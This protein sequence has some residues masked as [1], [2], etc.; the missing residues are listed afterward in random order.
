MNRFCLDGRVINDHFPGIGRYPFNLTD[1]LAALAPEDLFIVLHHPDQPNSRYD[2]ERLARHDNVMLQPVDVTAFS[3]AQQ[4]RLPQRLRSLAPDVYHAP[5]YIY[6][7]H[8]PYPTVVTLFDVI[9]HTHPQYLP[10]RH[11]RLIFEVT[12]R[13]ALRSAQRVLVPSRGTAEVVQRSYRVPSD[14][15]VVTP[16][17]ADAQF[18]LANTEAVGK[19]R[20]RY[21]LPQRYVLYLGSNK[22]HKNLLWLV[23]AWARVLRRRR[24]KEEA[25]LVI[26]GHTDP[27]YPQAQAHATALGVD[28]SV[29]FLGSVPEEDLPPLYSGA[30]CF[31]FP[32]LAEGFGLPVL[33]AMACGT[34]VLCGNLSSLPEVAGEAALLVNPY[35]VEAITGGLVRL[36]TDGDLRAELRQKGLARAAQFTWERTARATLAAYREVSG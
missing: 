19:V 5:Y 10:S 30:L 23:E 7:Y 13:L 18:R 29:R 21:D 34:P 25:I 27:R 32:S 12:T 36:L 15:V 16:L 26:A 1:A 31:A 6:P 24:K 17:A 8:L 9:S 4:W 3:L 22:P 35:D 28:K 14:K 11:A 33:E 20:S 2:L